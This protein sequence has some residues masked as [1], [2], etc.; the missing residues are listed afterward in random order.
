MDATETTP[1]TATPK[2]SALPPLSSAD[3]RT[4]NHMAEHMD[5]FH[6]HFR[7][8]WNMLYDSCVQ[9]K[10]AG[11]QSIRSFLSAGLQF[12]QQL[13]MHHGIEETYVFPMLAK[14]MPEFRNKEE[15]IAQHKQIHKGL[16]KL[17][18]S[19]EKCRSGEQELRLSELKVIM[20]SFG[21]VLWQHL[22]QEVKT[23]GAENMRRYWTKDEMTRMR[24]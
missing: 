20:D 14:K 3:F 10:R 8:S 17:Q 22:D 18:D 21:K 11:G 1:T 2:E 19:L 24:M 23:L 15:L 7:S 6:N 13:E 12:C 4:F 9:N 5:L 16:D